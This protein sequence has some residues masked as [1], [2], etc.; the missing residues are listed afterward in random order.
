MVNGVTTDVR[1]ESRTLIQSHGLATTAF[2]S[3]SDAQVA[4]IAARAERPRL[5]VGDN[6]A[7]R[8]GVRIALRGMVEIC[9]EADNATQAIRAAKVYQPEI[10]IIGDGL[11]GDTLAAVRGVCRVAPDAKVIVMAKVCNPEDMLDVVRSGA[12]GYVPS[13]VNVQHLRRI[14]GAV[15]ADE[16]AVPRTMVLDLLREVRAAGEEAAV[17]TRRETQV[18]GMLR[19]GQSTATIAERLEVAPVTVRR[20]ISALV[21]KL[22]VEDRSMLVGEQNR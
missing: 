14:V 15:A 11:G 9:A 18:L 2:E 8:L 21:H 13:D 6:G 3:D 16:A 7:T 22:G 19:R 10:C 12:V 5:M 17:L 4:Q 1:A 20:H